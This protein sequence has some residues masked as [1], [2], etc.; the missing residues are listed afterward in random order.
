MTL[1]RRHPATDGPDFTI[2][3]IYFYLVKGCADRLKK[4][5]APLADDRISTPTFSLPSSVV[6]HEPKERIDL[7]KLPL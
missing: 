2:P 4:D 6:Q 5:W 7:E 3:N 1:P